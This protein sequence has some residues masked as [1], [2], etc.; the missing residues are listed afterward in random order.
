MKR[1]L[2]AIP[3]FAI[4]ITLVSVGKSNWTIIWQYFGWSN[5]MLATMV[6]WAASVYLIHRGKFHWITTVPATFMTAVVITFIAYAKIG[7]NIDYQISVYIGIA[8]A[9]LIFTLLLTKVKSK[10]TDNK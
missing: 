9:A 8:V 3:L 5:Q 10:A 6:L 4:G 2:I 1:L 7:F